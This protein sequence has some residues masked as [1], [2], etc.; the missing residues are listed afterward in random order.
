MVLFITFQCNSG[1]TVLAVYLESV[2]L[3]E[4]LLAVRLMPHI[5]GIYHR[6]TVYLKKSVFKSV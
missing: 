6:I 5:L 1:L 2:L 4:S 3:L